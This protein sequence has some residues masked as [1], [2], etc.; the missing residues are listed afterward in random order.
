[1]PSA[2]VASDRATAVVGGQAYAN[3]TYTSSASSSDCAFTLNWEFNGGFQY[4]P[5]V[6][7]AEYLIYRGSMPGTGAALVS[8]YLKSKWGING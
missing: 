6:D 4:G 3:N 5:A 1:M 7:L 8:A 2:S